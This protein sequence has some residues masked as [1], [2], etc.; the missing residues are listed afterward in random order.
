MMHSMLKAEFMRLDDWCTEHRR[1]VAWIA[2][3]GL[4]NFVT[5]IILYLAGA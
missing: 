1:L 5:Q 4:L 2:F 3:W